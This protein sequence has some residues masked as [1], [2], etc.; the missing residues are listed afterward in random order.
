MAINYAGSTSLQALITKVESLLGNKVDK[1]SGKGLS[2]NDLTNELKD[3]YD[4][5]YTHSQAAHAPANA[6]RNVIVGVSINGSA[7]TIDPESRIAALTLTLPTKVSEL[8][9]DSGFQTA[10]QVST[11]ITTTLD[12]YYTKTDTDSKIA[13]AVAAASHLKY[14]IVESLPSQDID[15]NTVYLVLKDDVEGQDKYVEYMYIN[16]NWEIIGDTSVDLTNYYTKG[17]V[18]GL[19]A[20][21]VKTT[22]M[23][24]ISAEDVQGM[25]TPAA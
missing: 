14:Q 12:D 19:L 18:D 23:V 16:S 5:A 2:T 10:S 24:E 20:A 25:F 9:N 13:Q 6:E 22:D 11:A 21:Y 7:A 15:A 8:Q 1:V 17:D 3:Q 4:A